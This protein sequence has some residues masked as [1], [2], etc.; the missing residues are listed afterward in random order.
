MLAQAG[1]TH[2]SAASYN[3]HW[4]VPLTL[5]RMPA[6]TQ[7]R[8]VR[9]RHE[10]CGR[11]HAACRDGAAACRDH[12]DDRAGSSR[13]FRKPWMTIAD[14]KAEIF[15][16]LDAGRRCNP[17]SRQRCSSSVSADA[18]AAPARVTHSWASASMRKPTR[19][20]DEHVTLG[21]DHSIVQA[22]SLRPAADLS[23]RRARPPH[24]AELAR[25]APCRDMRSASTLELAA[26]A[27]AIFGAA[28][29]GAS[30]CD[31]SR[32]QWCHYADRRELQ[33]QSG[34]DARGARPCSAP[35]P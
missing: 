13:I 3:N 23:A 32:R 21:A 18:K 10:P 26:A 35:H 34:L 28:R 6:D 8:R 29:A 1:A 22:R 27:L 31:L 30:G 4:G 17:Q 33:R 11:N 9:N 14:A 2:A 12:H 5:A 20:L 24:G 16:G 19:R 25:G 7:L 15:S